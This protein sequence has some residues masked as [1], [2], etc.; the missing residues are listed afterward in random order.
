MI[1][2]RLYFSKRF[3]YDRSKNEWI[4]E[5]KGIGSWEFDLSVGGLF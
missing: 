1:P 5:N 4:L 3:H 2:I